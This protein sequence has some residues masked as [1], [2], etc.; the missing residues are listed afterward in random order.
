MVQDD[1]NIQLKL[2]TFWAVILGRVCKH[3]VLPSGGDWTDTGSAPVRL[4]LWSLQTCQ[5]QPKQAARWS[6][7]SPFS[8]HILVTFRAALRQQE[9]KASFYTEFIQ[10]TGAW[11]SS[12]FGTLG[13]TKKAI[14]DRAPVL[15]QKND[16][17]W[18]MMKL[19]RFSLSKALID[20]SL[21]MG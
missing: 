17:S 13:D 9:Q 21:G 10:R 4:S 8:W 19:S 11:G 16:G 7:D 5:K 1:F 2:V 12:V 6:S 15:N 14:N 3:K 20:T 18:Q